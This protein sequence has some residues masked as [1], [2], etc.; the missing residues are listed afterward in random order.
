MS[1]GE[2]HKPVLLDEAIEGL[3]RQTDG[4][5]IDGTFGRGG[6]S[7]SILQVLSPQGRLLAI[8]K[9]MDAVNSPQ[10]QALLKDERFELAHSSFAQMEQLAQERHWDGAVDG[11][12]LDLGVSSPQLDVAERGFSFM[13]DGPLDM[14]MDSTQGESAAQWLSHV[15]EGELVKVLRVYGEEKFA[16]KI[17]AEIVLQ[18]KETAIETTAQLAALIANVVKR[19]EPGKHPATRS[20]QAIRIKI[21]KELDDLEQAL[22][23]SLSMLKQGGRLAVISFHSLED[24]IVKRFIREQSRGEIVPRHLPMPL[25]AKKPVLKVV[26]KA[27]KASANEVAGNVRSRSAVLRIAEKL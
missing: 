18:R 5:Y 25:D 26:G 24:R 13:K 14:R 15:E 1:T 27:I 23:S 9:D 11:I 21:N 19:R 4:V 22:A 6:H 8:D 16:R 7:G 12:L 2:L 20:F 3:I 10:A 17:A